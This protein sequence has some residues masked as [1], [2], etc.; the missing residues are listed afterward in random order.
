MEC[1]AGAGL[2]ADPCGCCPAG[3]CGLPEGAKCFNASTEADLEARRLGV[4]GDN[5]DC[6]MRHDLGEAVSVVSV[7]S[8]SGPTAILRTVKR[9]I[10]FG[11]PFPR[12]WR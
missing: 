6:L 1:P 2:A 10:C 8:A 5:M 12:N 9:I 7:L 4:C 11:G 3:V